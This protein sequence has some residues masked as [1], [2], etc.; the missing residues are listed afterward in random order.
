M[1]RTILTI[2]AI[3]VALAA[4]AGAA[5][6]SPS[7]TETQQTTAIRILQWKLGCIAAHLQ[8]LYQHAHTLPDGTLFRTITTIRP[9]GRWIGGG[10]IPQACLYPPPVRP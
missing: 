9:G 5:Q 1:N 10:V 4:G 6:S 2:A 8:P 3:I 7:M